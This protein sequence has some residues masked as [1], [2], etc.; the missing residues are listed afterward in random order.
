MGIREPGIL[1]VDEFHTAIVDISYASCSRAGHKNCSTG[2]SQVSVIFQPIGKPIFQ[3]RTEAMRSC[4]LLWSQ[5]WSQRAR[6]LSLWRFDLRKLDLLWSRRSRSR[7]ESRKNVYICSFLSSL[8][9]WSSP[10]FHLKDFS[11]LFEVLSSRPSFP[12]T[13]L[14]FVPC[15]NREFK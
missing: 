8:P 1:F 11:F 3:Y 6:C 13:A 10:F 15:Y 14:W 7:T 12:A 9:D 4:D 5:R 2:D